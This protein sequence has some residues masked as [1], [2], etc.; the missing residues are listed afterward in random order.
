[1]LCSRCVVPREIDTVSAFMECQA[2]KTLPGHRRNTQLYIYMCVCVQTALGKMRE[3][4]LILGL[5]ALT[6]LQANGTSSSSPPSAVSLPTCA[7]TSTVPGT[8]PDANNTARC[9]W[10]LQGLARKKKMLTSRITVQDS[11]CCVHNKT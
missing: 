9:S 6:S 3:Y 11:A 5:P 4:S 1:M 7:G 8:V 10:G 2:G